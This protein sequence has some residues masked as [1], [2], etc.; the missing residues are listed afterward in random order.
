MRT[1]WRWAFILAG[2]AIL[3]VF[4]FLP[5]IHGPWQ[6]DDAAAIQF[7]KTIAAVVR[8]DWP[9][10]KTALSAFLVDT[11]RRPLAMATFAANHVFSGMNPTA[12]KLTN[13]FLHVLNA[14]LIYVLAFKLLVISKASLSSTTQRAVALFVTLL[15][16]LHAMQVSTVL[17]V[18]QR[19]EMLAVTFTLLG[20]LAYLKARMDMLAGR[21][22]WQW[23]AGVALCVGLGYACKENIVLLPLYALLTEVCVL[24]FRCA[25]RPSERVLRAAYVLWAI[26]FVVMLTRIFG[27]PNAFDWPN[28]EFSATERTLTQFRVLVDYLQ[29]SIWPFSNEL[30]FYH[31]DYVVSRGWL[32]PAST[33]ASA[34]LLAALAISAIALRRKIPLYAMGIGIWFVS[35][36]L[37]SAPLNLELVFEH[38]NYFAL[39]GL[40]LAIAGL[41]LKFSQPGP[42]GFTLPVRAMSLGL[43]LLFA[44]GTYLRASIWGDRL[45]FANDSYAMNPKSE[46]AATLYAATLMGS[47]G[48]EKGK[49]TP[50]YSLAIQALNNA[51]ALPNSTALPEHLLIL[52]AA[53]AGEPIDPRWWST[54]EN[55]YKTSACGV[56]NYNAL[57]GLAMGYMSGELTRDADRMQRVFEAYL[58]RCPRRADAHGLYADFAFGILS[59]EILAARQMGLWSLN[60]H[61]DPK[62]RTTISDRLKRSNRLLELEAIQKAQAISK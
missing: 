39:F 55:K 48:Y 62:V 46:R 26:L 8:F 38:R 60:Y 19:M 23:M 9:T 28:R 24:H 59:D 61:G 51:S 1:E 12:Y 35:H 34:A 17:Y 54:I 22:G 18:V 30:T 31:D 42:D 50:F 16:A 15:W 52:S 40:L 45:L 36:I 20:L 57:S 49:G 14:G 32:A 47:I 27:S 4:A 58:K 5:G 21:L 44:F 6:F 37:I 2:A 10:W 13:I 11:W 25:S 33:L 3:I 7:N 53:R 56:E 41:V 43:V 29:W